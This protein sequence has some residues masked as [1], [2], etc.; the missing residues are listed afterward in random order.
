MSLL[1]IQHG[2]RDW[3]IAETDAIATHCPRRAGAGLSVYL[4]TYRG[5]LMACLHE[6]YETVH[7]WLGDEAFGA[8]A[9]THIDHVPPSSWTLDDYALAFPDTV[10][11]LYPDDP[12]VCEL[13]RLER[14]LA[15]AFTAPDHH[16]I[17]PGALADLDWDRVVFRFA[18]GLALIPATTNAAAIWSAIA[19]GETPPPAGTLADAATTMIWRNGFTPAFRTLEA[20]DAEVLAGA[21]RGDRF[22]TLCSML[23]ERLGDAEGTARAGACLAQWMADGII[24]GTVAAPQA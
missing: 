12:E 21:L 5:Q 13:A 7:A 6:S 1:E 16:A 11:R 9:A 4:N 19:Q 2:L 3:L 8:V 18:P 20:R 15:A 17:E 24:M 23:V 22:G 14:A 10:S